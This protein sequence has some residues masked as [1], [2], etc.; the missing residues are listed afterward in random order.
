MSLENGSKEKADDRE[1][2][3]ARVRGGRAFE[4]KRKL[5][6]PA[7]IKS[8]GLIIVSFVRGLI[9]IKRKRGDN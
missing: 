8:R 3:C 1:R 4:M 9:K 5:Q 6:H 2:F 7:I